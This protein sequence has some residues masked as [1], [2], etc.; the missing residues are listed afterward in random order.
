MWSLR[1]RP[2][3]VPR[4]PHGLDERRGDPAAT[5][6]ETGTRPCAERRERPE[7]PALRAETG[8]AR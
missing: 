5:R 7:A 1:A 2:G 4:L 8:S 6:P 3:F